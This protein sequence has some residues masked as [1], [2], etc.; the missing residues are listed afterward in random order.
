MIS[1]RSMTEADWPQVAQIY[2]EGITTGIATFETAVPAY[3]KWN[4]VHAKSCRLVSISDGTVLD[5][6]VSGWAALSPVSSRRVYS[7]V[8]EVSVYVG[9]NY[10]GQHIGQILL[11]ALIK[12]SEKEGYWTLQSTIL[13][14]NTVSIA[15]HHK[16]GFRTV[17]FRERAARDK[18]G[19]WHN[20]LLLERRSAVV[21]LE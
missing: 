3:E 21:G 10:R 11:D 19:T 15:L 5:G 12:E 14:E 1:I 13:E 2:Q 16:C 17:G 7:G 4:A 6:A 8:A 9:G 20:T 18:N